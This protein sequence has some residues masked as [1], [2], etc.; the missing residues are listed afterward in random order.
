MS[1]T[2]PWVV[3]DELGLTV[4]SDRPPAF[5]VSRRYGVSP[6]TCALYEVAAI[7]VGLP[8]NMDGSLGS[9]AQKN[10]PSSNTSGGRREYRSSLGMNV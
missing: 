10:L 9:Q 4:R 8:K 2:N 5:V 3:S 7:V 6:R 1:A